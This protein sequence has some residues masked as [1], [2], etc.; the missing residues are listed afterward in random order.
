MQI[1]IHRG[2][3]ELKLLDKRINSSIKDIK[4]VGVYKLS[5]DKVIGTMLTQKEFADQASADF[6]SIKDLIT[7]RDT[8]KRAIVLSNA[9]TLVKI[10]NKEYTVAEAIERKNSIEYDKY[11]LRM[12]VSQ[13]AHATNSLTSKM[14]LMNTNIEKQLETILGNN[15]ENDVQYVETFTDSYKKRNG[16]DI[17]DPIDIDKVIETLEKEIEDF[18]TEVDAT[19][20]ESNATTF[21]EV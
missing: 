13:K 7:R 16:F 9:K 4:A 17:V 6:N 15:K 12:L 11:L 21:I 20:S 8:I 10:A 19:L 2:L 18:E 3:A 5:E 1:S 14:D